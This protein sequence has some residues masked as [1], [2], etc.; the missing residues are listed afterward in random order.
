MRHE[1]WWGKCWSVEWTGGLDS[2]VLN[3]MNAAQLWERYQEYLCVIPELELSL[4]ISRMAFAE[5]FF[6]KMEPA[7]Q[8][9]FDAMAELEKGA[10]ANPDENRMVGHYWLRAPE[11]AP[12]AEI[13]AEI[14]R[15]LDSVRS[16]AAGVHSGTLRP[17]KAAAFKQLLL[18]GIGGSALGPMFVADALGT[19]HDPMPV[20]FIDNTDPDGIHRVLS[21]LEEKLPETLCVVT[22]K[23]GGTPETRNG[24]LVVAEAYRTAGLDF[25]KQAVAITMAGSKMDELAEREGWLARI[26]MFD[27]VGGRTSELS[28]VGLLPAAL[29]GID[30]DGLLAGAAACDQATRIRE[31]RGNPAALMALM[32]H[33]A[34]EGRGAKDMVVLPYKDRLLLLGRYLQQ[35]IMESLG[36]RLNLRGERV[37]QGLTVYG[38]KGSTDQHAYV[39]Q[40]RDGVANFFVT[41]VRVLE[42]G[43]N[44]FQVDPDVSSG[45][46]LHGFLLGT[47]AALFENGRQSLTI[48]VPKVDAVRV[49]ALIALF[50]RAVGFYA[51]LIGI[52]AYHQPGVEAG[53]KAAA[54][55]LALHRR[56]LQQLDDRPRTAEQLAKE[57]G[58]EQE[59]ETIYLHLEHLSANRCAKKLS[60]KTVGE[61]C[62]TRA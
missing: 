4:D 7:M 26:P 47:R 44:G 25:A 29:Q 30:I 16:L 36:K 10:C 58:A 60:A 1:S 23:S 55:V 21:R 37:D 9:A 27:W 48:T 56:I 14:R 5:D 40:L 24:M 13:G 12:T 8:A 42:S 39:Q 38:N 51:N 17:P 19:N 35:L 3:S 11:L 31:T 41:F 62:F 2:Y 46:Y 6:Q 57:L 45:D 59:V 18:V 53:K 33:H 34:T 28:A 61:I 52:N 20:E 50:E 54:A 32:W 43:G 15:T 49:G 22:S